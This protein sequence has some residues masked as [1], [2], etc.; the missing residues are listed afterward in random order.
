MV[1]MAASFLVGVQ[2]ARGLGVTGYGYYALALSIITVAG[3]PG[4]LGLSRLVTRETAA[5]AT[6]KN[7]AQIIG[8]LRWADR[9]CL[10]LSLLMIAAVGVAALLLL[11]SKPTLAL[12]LLFGA[13]V[14]PLMAFSRIRGGALQGLQH[15]VRGQIPAIVLKPIFLSILLALVFLFRFPLDA[16]SAM[17]LNAATAALVLL[18]AHVWLK[19]RL[20]A[21][22]G[23]PPV[24]SQR[25]W[26]AATIPFA[27]TDGMR[28]LQS[29]LTV[30]LL[31]AIAAPADVGLFRIAVATATVTAAPMTVL[32]QV[33]VPIIARLYADRD[34]RRL[35]LFVS[36]VAYAQTA[37]VLAL[38]LPLLIAPEF[39]LSL[40]FGE[41]FAP[42][43]NA[44][45]IVLV[46]Q[47][48]NAA[49]GPNTTL[50]NMGHQERRVTRAM[51]VGLALNFVTVIL[52]VRSMGIE[53]A[54]IGLV[55]SLMAWNIQTWFDGRR[56][57]G[58]ETS[59]LPIAARAS[60]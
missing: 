37:A 42:A 20:P 36:Y 5:A 24:A 48:A 8:V 27:L 17:V 18:I 22:F 25:E 10:H 30:L 46:G 3:I 14:I 23:A 60:R 31:G 34:L 21:H 57:L 7:A 11:E 40:A 6:T 44:M 2:L 38:S 9:T 50:L 59:I 43:A 26:L 1:A 47:I 53:G 54:A 16:P 32:I 58:I 4:E 51:A 49:F 29:E 13:P 12:S 56:I 45:R 35:Q 15:I 19:N 41:G 28:L 55:L 33:A 52:L 39:F